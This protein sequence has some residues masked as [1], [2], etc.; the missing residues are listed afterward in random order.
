MAAENPDR[1]AVRLTIPEWDKWVED[2]PTIPIKAPNGE[3]FDVLPAERWPDTAYDALEAEAPARAVRAIL[4]DRYDAWVATGANSAYFLDRV[5]AAT[6][7]KVG[8]S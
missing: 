3:T 4:G 2:H 7:V 1:V 8:E 6:G 5:G